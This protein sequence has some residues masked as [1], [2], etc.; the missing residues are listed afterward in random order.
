MRASV[1]QKI[2]RAHSRLEKKRLKF[3]LKRT[4]GIEPLI[5]L[6]ID[7]TCIRFVN[8][9]HCRDFVRPKVKTDFRV[10]LTLL[11]SRLET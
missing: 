5:N 10:S 11:Y 1:V 6:L 4:A 3:G 7:K 8:L 2:E 9:F